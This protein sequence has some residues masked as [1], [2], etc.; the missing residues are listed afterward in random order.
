MEKIHKMQSWRVCAL[1]LLGLQLVGQGAVLTHKP[2]L[3]HCKKINRN[4][5]ERVKL[6]ARSNRLLMANKVS[7]SGREMSITFHKNT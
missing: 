6:S 5:R 3:A 4:R 1:T 2:F 7:K